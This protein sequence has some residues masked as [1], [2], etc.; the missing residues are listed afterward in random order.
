MGRTYDS[1]KC[2]SPDDELDLGEPPVQW[3][4]CPACGGEGG[5]EKTI[6]VYE[7]GCGFSH[8]DGWWVICETCNGAGGQIVEAKEDY[9][10]TDHQRNALR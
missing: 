3:E 10:V 1:W 5:Y 2:R 7:A 4:D 6:H 8:P 9:C